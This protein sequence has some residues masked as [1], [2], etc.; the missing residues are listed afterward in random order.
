M[1][2][3]SALAE[4]RKILFASSRSA[5]RLK[6]LEGSAR[7]AFPQG[8]ANV[9]A[10]IVCIKKRGALVGSI[11]AIRTHPTTD[12]GG[13]F[14][15]APIRRELARSSEYGRPREPVPGFFSILRTSRNV[16]YINTS[17]VR[18]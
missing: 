9:K 2:V 11:K 6:R 5:R 13:G 3:K 12:A 1:A 16:I 10:Y 7:P 8:R 17:L 18:R 14:F 4:L 15:E